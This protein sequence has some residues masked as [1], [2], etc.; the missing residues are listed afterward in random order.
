MFDSI[1][2]YRNV[3]VAE[4]TITGGDGL[5][6]RVRYV[7]RRFLPSSAG[8]SVTQEHVVHDGDRLDNITARYIGDPTLF[9]NICDLNDAMNPFDLTTKIGYPL[10]ITGLNTKE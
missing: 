6:R 2:R 1:S 9:W 5:D 8:M 3:E 10:R 7:R 4:T